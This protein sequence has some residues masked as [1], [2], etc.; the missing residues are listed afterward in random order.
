M[1]NTPVKMRP[2]HPSAAP[3]PAD[4][5]GPGG[6][7]APNAIREHVDRALR[8]AARPSASPTDQAVAIQSLVA[9]VQLLAD[10]LG[11]IEA[12]LREG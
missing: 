1:E 10:R 9:A 2:L 8:E 5:P 6:Q 7:A 12:R 3:V 4:R 11:E